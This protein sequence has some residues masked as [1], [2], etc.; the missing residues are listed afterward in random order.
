VFDLFL[1]LKKYWKKDK[2]PAISIESKSNRMVFVVIFYMKWM[3]FKIL[4]FFNYLLRKLSFLL[5]ISFTINKNK[6]ITFS[7]IP[8]IST[9]F[10]VKNPI[11]KC[12]IF[13]KAPKTVN[14]IPRSR[15]I[16]I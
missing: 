3:K 15:I 12:I 10:P 9:M 16:M 1:D 6:A 8:I 11:S 4:V 5:L 7:S 14:K 13:N 2:P